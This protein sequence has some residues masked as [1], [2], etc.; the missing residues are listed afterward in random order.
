MLVKINNKN[1]LF[2]FFYKYYFNFI[3]AGEDRFTQPFQYKF[4]LHNTVALFSWVKT[5]KAMYSYL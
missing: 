5:D 2:T 4:Y 1:C 3:M